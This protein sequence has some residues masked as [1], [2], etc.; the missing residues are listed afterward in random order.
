RFVE[1]Q[2]SRIAEARKQ[3]EKT[4]VTFIGGHYAMRQ[5]AADTFPQVMANLA[6][7]GAHA[8]VMSGSGLS[9][10]GGFEEE[11]A[12]KKAEEM[13]RLAKICHSN[14]LVFA[15]HNHNPEFANHNA[16]I[17]ALAEA[18]DPKLVS[19]L[20]DAGHGYWG[21]GNP[22]HFMARHSKRIYGCHVKTFK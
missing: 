7:M 1:G 4:G 5:A 11:K 12:L 2:F 17:E 13:N 6:A 9:P 18:T 10:E 21:G 20:M 8:V 14:G 3:I 19:F 16:E 15:Y 22:A